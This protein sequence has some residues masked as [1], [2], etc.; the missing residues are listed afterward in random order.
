MHYIIF[1]LEGTKLVIWFNNFTGTKMESQR[2]EVAC[3]MKSKDP[4]LEP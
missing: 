2:D 3:S 4:D 1:N